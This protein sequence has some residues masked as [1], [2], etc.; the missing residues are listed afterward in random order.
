MYNKGFHYTGGYSGIMVDCDP[1][2]GFEQNEGLHVWCSR[3]SGL[4]ETLLKQYR[5][6]LDQ[7]NLKMKKKTSVNY[8]LVIDQD[9]SYNK[10]EC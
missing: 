10:A 4:I 7:V 8:R 3:P 1:L 6:I 9:K 2:Y 5:C